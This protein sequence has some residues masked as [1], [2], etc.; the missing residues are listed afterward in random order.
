MSAFFDDGRD[1]LLGGRL[2]Q[3]P[4]GVPNDL[5]STRLHPG[6]DAANQVIID[7]NDRFAQIAALY[8]DTL[9]KPVLQKALTGDRDFDL[10]TLNELRDDSI[11]AT[12]EQLRKI[13]E[14]AKEQNPL[15]NSLDLEHF[16]SLHKQI[17][18]YVAELMVGEKEPQSHLRKDGKHHVIAHPLDVVLLAV[19]RSAPSIKSVQDLYSVMLV[20]QFHD[21]I[22]DCKQGHDFARKRIQRI[23]KHEGVEHSLAESVLKQ[24]EILTIKLTSI[25]SSSVDSQTKSFDPIPWARKIAGYE[26]L[27]NGKH[28]VTEEYFESLRLK[29]D[30][31][32]GN[33]LDLLE[34]LQ[35]ADSSD[36]PLVVSQILAT[37]QAYIFLCEGLLEKGDEF[38][39]SAVQRAKHALELNQCVVERYSDRTPLIIIQ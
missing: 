15:L 28:Q 25:S 19:E 36:N 34:R 37:A 38:L 14:K 32:L 21:C 30:D 18:I 35:K 6:N 11:F 22:E 10:R 20:A 27:L 29:A 13:I 8:K 2:S 9:V 4:H 12:S 1:P 3:L 17:S 16:A 23:L 33:S 39:A 7:A 5:G 31:C 26:Y 24:V